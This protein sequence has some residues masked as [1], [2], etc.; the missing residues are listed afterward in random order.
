MANNTVNLMSIIWEI[1]TLVKISTI[2]P[3]IRNDM[4]INNNFNLSLFYINFN[5]YNKKN[6][7]KQFTFLFI[8]RQ[9]QQRQWL[10][11]K[12]WISFLFAIMIQVNEIMWMN[13]IW[14]CKLNKNRN[15]FINYLALFISNF[16]N[17]RNIQMIIKN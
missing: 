12:S 4:W 8:Q 3:I 9:Q 5:V 1:A 13:W 7:F 15:K 14:F 16:W 6:L 11:K 17:E 10:E 2:F